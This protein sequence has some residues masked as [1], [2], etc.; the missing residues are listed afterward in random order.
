MATP[1]RQLETETLIPPLDLWL[2]GRPTLFQSRLERL[3]IAQIIHDA[4]ESIRTRIRRCRNCLQTYASPLDLSLANYGR[5][6]QR[7]VMERI[8]EIKILQDWKEGR[9]PITGRGKA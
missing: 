7:S 1:I 9:K 3:A 4:C 2:N 6:G 8:R 5:L